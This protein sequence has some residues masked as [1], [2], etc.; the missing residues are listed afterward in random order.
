ME[1]IRIIEVPVGIRYLTQ[2]N[3]FSFDKFPSKCIIDKQL[4]GC[5]MTEYCLLS[6][7]ENVIICSPRKMLMQNK[8]DQHGDDVYLVVN[9]MDQDPNVDKDISK[10]IKSPKSRKLFGGFDVD[11]QED[12][13][14]ERIRKLKNSIIRERIFKELKKYMEKMLFEHKPYKILVTYDSY[15]LIKK[16][17][18]EL[19]IFHTFYTVIDEF[20]SILHDARFKSDTENNFLNELNKSHSAIFVSATPMMKEYIDMLKDF[21]NLPYFQLDW[22][23]Q[24]P[25]RIVSPSL[26]VRTMKSVGTKAKEI[27]T[28]FLN[29]NR[30]SIIVN[31]DG[32]PTPI[33]ANE[34]V[35]YVNSV[36]HIINIIKTNELAPD[37][38][39]IL[40]SDTEENKS[41]IKNKL[42]KE[43]SI[44]IIPKRGE[45]HKPITFCTR[46]VY[47]GADFY[48]TCAKSY[49]FADSNLDSL[50]VDISEDLPQILG[51][52]RLDENPWKNSATFYYR[53][54]C[55]YHEVPQ[56]KFKK[57]LEKKKKNTESLIKIYN[58]TKDNSDK[59]VLA[60][61]Y[62]KVA[63]SYSYR[64]D[65]VAVNTIINSTTGDKILK[66][67][68]NELV[69]VNEIRA[70]K[71]QQIDYKDR[72]TVFNTITNTIHSGN[73][74]INSFV[75][76]L[77]N[78]YG[79]LS[80]PFD[81]LKLVIGY[82][83]SGDRDKKEAVEIF[84]HQLSDSDYV[85]M[86]YTNLGPDKIKSV[87]CNITQLKKALGIKMFDQS[88]LEKEIYDNF[89]E[90]DKLALSD[91][92]SKLTLIY[93]SVE[94]R[95]TPKAIDIQEYF[96]VKNCMFTDII[97]GKKKRINGYELIKRLK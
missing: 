36:N 12:E 14:K 40:C 18:V 93:D 69:L 41:R 60:K 73:E 54:T 44:G 43:Y 21:K 4:P 49:V 37:Q 35:L 78:F 95:A 42:G 31:R 47:L 1:D 64:D 10:T 61:N 82:Y 75:K 15:H 58:N 85:K 70:F 97:D 25:T 74:I 8:K 50:A 55:N 96:E 32:Q 94:Y 63:K 81:R 88:K 27:I 19:G 9:E 38:V 45:Y 79:Q 2:W 67:I 16:M 48:S 80:A 29:G 62:Q 22:I 39:N 66:P 33:F 68:E 46:T 86:Y 11:E 34:I 92:K 20:Q 89:K 6:Q 13:E 51:R 52:Q 23:K 59:Y 5:G 65:Y 30:D 53:T 87:G 24:D 57:I 3:D 7:N 90:G 71:I 91:I 77:M 72:F 84:I 76:D 17:L 56:E 28:N 83:F 26:E